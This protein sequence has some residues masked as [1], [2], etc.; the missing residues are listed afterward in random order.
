MKTRITITL[1]PEIHRR[2]KRTAQTRHTT[3]SGLIETLLQSA[4]TASQYP[5]LV[6]DMLGA[7]VLRES[8]PGKDALYD[9]LRDRHIKRR[10]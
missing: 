6:D 5:S 9:A 4:D 3:V 8:A 1:E 10:T 2:A 7:G